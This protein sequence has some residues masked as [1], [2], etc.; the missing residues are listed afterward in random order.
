MILA[1]YTGTTSVSN[2]LH[3]GSCTQKLVVSGMDAG[4]H[5]KTLPHLS[6]LNTFSPNWAIL[7]AHSLTERSSCTTCALFLPLFWIHTTGR[8]FFNDVTL[9]LSGLLHLL[10]TTGFHPQTSGY[11]FWSPFVL[12][13]R[14]H[15]RLVCN[16][17]W[18]RH[19]RGSQT[20]PP[21]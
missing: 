13:T 12:F 8:G 9:P 3:Y 2:S 16:F 21:P 6:R 7:P 11:P 14:Y 15:T 17:A 4:T 5:W 18:N 20:E 10:P 1:R 19:Q